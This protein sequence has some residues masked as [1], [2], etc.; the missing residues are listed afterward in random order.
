MERDERSLR[1]LLEPVNFITVQTLVSERFED[2]YDLIYPFT[3]LNDEEIERSKL[4][5]L[6][7]AGSNYIIWGTYWTAVILQP[8]TQDQ[9]LE[10]ATESINTY[11]VVT[12]ETSDIV[13]LLE[14]PEPVGYVYQLIVREPLIKQPDKNCIPDCIICCDDMDCQPRF[15]ANKKECMENCLKACEIF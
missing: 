6:H 3:E 1:V 4:A 7:I 12:I 15:G 10:L 2:K 13:R 8:T 5:D 9:L 14:A 11:G